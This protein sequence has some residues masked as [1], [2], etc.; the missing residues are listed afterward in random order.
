MAEGDV[1]IGMIIVSHGTYICEIDASRFGKPFRLKLLHMPAS[2]YSLV[3]HVEP[4][5]ESMSPS[6]R[7]AS[8]DGS[9]VPGGDPSGLAEQRGGGSRRVAGLPFGGPRGSFR[10]PLPPSSS[11]SQGGPARIGPW[12]L[13]CYVCSSYR[14]WLKSS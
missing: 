1:V 14:D 4:E 5:R 12:L 11:S 10:R 13:R 3:L 6:R 2:T 9:W 8:D 7:R